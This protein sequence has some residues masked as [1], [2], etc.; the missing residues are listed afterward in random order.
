[1]SPCHTKRYG[2]GYEDRGLPSFD[3]FLGFL[4]HIDFWPFILFARFLFLSLFV[5][6]QSGICYH[7]NTE[8]T[9]ACMRCCWG[10]C[11]QVRWVIMTARLPTRFVSARYQTGARVPACWRLVDRRAECRA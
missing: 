11:E 8:S 9:S 7:W 1:L 5:R 6:H 10:A 3:L 4:F 2:F